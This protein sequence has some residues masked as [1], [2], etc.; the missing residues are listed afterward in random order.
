MEWGDR[1]SEIGDAKL[2]DVTEL[3]IRPGPAV[4]ATSDGLSQLRS[5]QHVDD[6]PWGLRNSHM[7]TSA[8]GLFTWANGSAEAIPR[9]R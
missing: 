3:L 5:F 8:R 6:Q 2:I 4:R 9:L 1:K 7:T